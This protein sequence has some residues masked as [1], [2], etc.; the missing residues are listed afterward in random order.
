MTSS[1]ILAVALLS[2]VVGASNAAA[3]D[4]LENAKSLYASAAYEA[5]LTMLARV[6]RS[7]PASE[8]QQYRAFCLIALGRLGEAEKAIASVVTENPS[9]VPSTDDVSPRIH[10]VFVR[11]RRELLPDIVKQLYQSGKTALEGKDRPSAIAAF[12]SLV[13]LIDASDADTRDALDEIRFLA[14]GFLDLA[15]AQPAA[16]PTSSAIE[17]SRAAPLKSAQTP[18]DITPPVA[19]R[20]TMPTWTPPD[21]YSSRVTFQGAVRVNI[22][23]Q[24][25]VEEAEIVRPVH[26]VY[27]RLL[28]KA[29]KDWVYQPARRGGVPTASEQV[30]E[31]QLKPRQ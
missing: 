29:A 9:F 10:D 31:V 13:R 23:A 24:G 4:S 22:S 28:L 21:A 27:D 12:D 16:A 30:V 2:T 17:S 11:T 5:A 26:P 3:Q 20:Q 7:G 15:R 14:A 6:D 19:V 18:L 8:V 25:S 1:R